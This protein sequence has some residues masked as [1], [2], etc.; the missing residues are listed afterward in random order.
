MKDDPTVHIARLAREHAEQKSR[1]KKSYSESD[2]AEL[3]AQSSLESSDDLDALKRR[4][5]Q[6]FQ[7][8]SA[9][10]RLTRA[11]VGEIAPWR[12]ISDDEGAKSDKKT[13]LPGGGSMIVLGLASAG[14]VGLVVAAAAAVLR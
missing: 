13:L 10:K 9:D 5:D 3:D 2:F 12:N 11:V 14:L 7:S 4:L 1:Q 6:D 8:I